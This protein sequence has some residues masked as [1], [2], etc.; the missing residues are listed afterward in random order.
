MAINVIGFILG[1]A[2][3][4]RRGASD[5]DANRAGLVGAIV[6]PP[7]L[8]VVLAAA[9]RV[10]TPPVARRVPTVTSI[11]PTSGPAAGG[12]S[13]TITGTNL[14]NATSVTFGVTAGT[15]T[16]NTSTLVT[17]TTPAGAAGAVNVVVTTAGGTATATN[18]YT[19]L[20]TP[21]ITSIAPSSGPV[22]GGQSVVITGT[23]LS[24]VSSITFG[25]TAGTI[26]ANTTSTSVTVTTPAGVAGA[27]SVV[28]TATAGSVTFS[29]YTYTTAAP[30]K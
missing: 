7:I 14:T 3:A 24:G 11:A 1:R 29:G 12:Q 28:V 20:A 27:V 2:V 30:T 10:A 15:I 26:T 23:N 5:Q 18:G 21:T 17:V 4:Q 6:K 25:A 19:Y 22:A 13:V 16:A 8:G 9:S